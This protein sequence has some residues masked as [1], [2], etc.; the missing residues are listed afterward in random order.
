L[1][2]VKTAP[3]APKQV[4]VTTAVKA[5]EAYC[6]K[7]FKDAKDIRLEEVELS[8]RNN[9]WH[10]TLSFTTP[11]RDSPIGTTMRDVVTADPFGL[12][13]PTDPQYPRYYRL[14]LIDAASGSPRAMKMRKV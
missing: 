11:D 13:R 3:A 6:H 8:L 7:L 9:T 14:F 2:P 4:D 10:I 12:D 1:T 5:A